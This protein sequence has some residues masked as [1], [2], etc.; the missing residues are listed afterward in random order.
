VLKP[1]IPSLFSSLVF[2]NKGSLYPYI[3]APCFPICPRFLKKI[4]VRQ[5]DLM[6]SIVV[7]SEQAC[8]RPIN[9]YFL[10]S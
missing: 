8:L 1:R 3:L 2:S 9:S 6:K 4:V 5:K 7:E 10:K